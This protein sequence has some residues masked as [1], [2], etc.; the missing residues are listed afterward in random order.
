M[1]S[2]ARMRNDTMLEFLESPSST[3]PNPPNKFCIAEVTWDAP[4]NV[5]ADDR[6]WTYGDPTA[7]G[8]G[9]D[10]ISTGETCAILLPGMEDVIHGSSGNVVLAPLVEMDETEDIGKLS[11]SL[12]P[13][14]SSFS[15]RRHLAL[16][17]WNQTLNKV[18]MLTLAVMIAKGSD[19]RSHRNCYV[20][21]DLFLKY[22]W[23]YVENGRSKGEGVDLY[24][25]I[26]NINTCLISIIKT[27]SCYVEYVS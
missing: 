20:V 27:S 6:N 22:K 14:F 26:L 8:D 23:H 13:A 3:R 7:G 12:K 18:K 17:F 9:D 19:Y 1:C 16:L 5:C 11:D 4:V 21:C 24:R 15:C 25:W 2:R 10:V